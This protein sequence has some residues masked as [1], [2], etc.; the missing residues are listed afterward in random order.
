MPE[1]FTSKMTVLSRQAF[2]NAVT[3]NV[4]VA[5]ASA[6]LAAVPAR[7]FPDILARFAPAEASKE[8]LVDGL[9]GNDPS[10]NR[11]S[12]DK[13]VRGWLSGK[14]RPTARDDL[15]ELCFILK[16]SAEKAD[17]FL[18]MTSEEGIHWRDPKELAF[19]FALEKG[20]NYPE[21]KQL[22]E[23]VTPEKKAAGEEPQRNVFTQA[24]RQEASRIETEE[25]LAQYL[26]DAREK[27]GEYHNRA[28]Q[29][30]TAYLS[31][32]EK[33]RAVSTDEEES[34][35]IRKIVETYLDNRFPASWDKKKL[36]E[37]R[38]GILAGWP[39]EIT[40]S[41]MKTGKTDVNRKTMML[42]FLATD[43]GEEIS[44]EWEEDEDWEDEEEDDPEADFRS[45]YMRMNQ[46]LSSCGYC[47]LDPRNP[48]DWVVLYCMRAGSDPDAM[49]GLSEH[50]SDML[51]MLFTEDQPETE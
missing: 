39:D 29:Q 18:A 28:Y 47:M 35:T 24:V 51:E 3:L 32:L 11:A 25:E 10:R 17:G 34:Y 21:A 30:F 20:M 44:E 19:A 8:K 31:L 23:R 7:S 40:L 26:R 22:L 50:L 1:D 5:N 45:S 16:L 38:Q 43:G 4:S 49:E 12:M 14:Y 2:Q 41:R 13:K 36:D 6:A 27:L 9:C 42:L 37:K 33:P 15:W 48:F 46:M